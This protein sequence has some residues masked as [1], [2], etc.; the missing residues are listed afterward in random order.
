MKIGEKA[1]AEPAAVQAI[2]AA[3]AGHARARGAASGP[4][5]NGIDVSDVARAA[6]RLLGRV[7]ETT[8]DPA[9]AAHLAIL[10]NA[11]ASGRYQPDLREV[12][13]RLLVEVA[14]ERAS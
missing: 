14:A 3:R 8:P 2:L 1:S 6:A 12:A 4:R 11:V 10:R 13:R 9:R 7:D 5:G